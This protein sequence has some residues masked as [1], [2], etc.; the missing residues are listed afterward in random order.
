[1][2]RNI[3][4]N[5]ALF[6]SLAFMPVFGA[7]PN[8]VELN[9]EITF[10][11]AATSNPD[12][13][14]SFRYSQS[15]RERKGDYIQVAAR[16]ERGEA[17]EYLPLFVQQELVEDLLSTCEPPDEEFCTVIVTSAF[18]YGQDKQGTSRFLVFHEKSQKPYQHR[19]ISTTTASNFMI[20]A[21]ELS[22]KAEKVAESDVV[23][24]HAGVGVSMSAQAAVAAFSEVAD[25]GKSYVGD[26]LRDF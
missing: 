14:L 19:F 25:L 23:R 15:G 18:Q 26:F 16:F 2:P 21:E 22:Q 7:E 3:Y 20:G 9:D 24:D 1:M 17:L 6:C 11:R 5:L 10:R 4:N 12:N 13:Q 8:L